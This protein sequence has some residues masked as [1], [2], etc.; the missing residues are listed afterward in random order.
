[1]SDEMTSVSKRYF[2]ETFVLP[3]RVDLAKARAEAA[4]LTPVHLCEPA[5]SILRQGNDHG[6]W[7]VA[8]LDDDSF[9]AM[10]APSEEL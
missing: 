2:T 5:F 1:M 7:R 9:L 3:F 6:Y 8:S 10:H 4:E